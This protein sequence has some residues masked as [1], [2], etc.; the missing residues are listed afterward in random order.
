MVIPKK[1]KEVNNFQLESLPS[2]GEIMN[3]TTAKF[4]KPRM[5]QNHRLATALTLMTHK[6][7]K[8]QGTDMSIFYRL[9]WDPF[10]EAFSVDRLR[11]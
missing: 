3:Y 10:S 8:S 1:S 7:D 11:P 9:S 5:V 6:I 2:S 4:Q